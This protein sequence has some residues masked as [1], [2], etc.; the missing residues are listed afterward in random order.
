MENDKKNE[1]G[2]NV[3]AKEP[4]WLCLLEMK[5]DLL[6]IDRLLRTQISINSKR[7]A[8]L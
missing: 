3:L 2:T 5:R 7:K 8:L 6:F 4:K 1:V